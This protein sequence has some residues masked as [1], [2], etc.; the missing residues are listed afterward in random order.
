MSK[1]KVLKTGNSLAVT[2]PSDFVHTVG[3]KTG[4]QVKVE[5]LPEAGQVVYTFTGSKQL[6]L[7][8]N[9]IRKKRR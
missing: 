2:I 1:Q 3:I 6:P 8:N 5:V 7:A 4:Q 9:F